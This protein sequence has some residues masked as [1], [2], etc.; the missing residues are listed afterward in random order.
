LFAQEGLTGLVANGGLSS[1]IDH[2]ESED[3]E[4]DEDNNNNNNNNNEEE[5]EETHN[6][7]S[8][9]DFFDNGGLLDP[10]SNTSGS[11]ASNSLEYISPETLLKQPT[12]V[13]VPSKSCPGRNSQDQKFVLTPAISRFTGARLPKPCGDR[14]DPS[15]DSET[16]FIKEWLENHFGSAGGD[17]EVVMDG[18]GGGGGGGGGGGT[19]ELKVMGDVC[20]FYLHSVRGLGSVI[21]PQG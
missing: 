15:M 17:G 16:S 9:V 20:F 6:L 5:E 3:E 19:F 10:D 14:N 18:N 11:N 13:W 21:L 7:N 12:H 4:E 2:G 8:H 1:N